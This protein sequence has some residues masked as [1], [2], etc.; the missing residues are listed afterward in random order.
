MKLGKCGSFYSGSFCSSRSSYSFCRLWSISIL[1]AW[2]VSLF[3]SLGDFSSRR[4]LWFSQQE[5][6]GT[7]STTPHPH[8]PPTMLA[9]RMVAPSVL[10]GW[11]DNSLIPNLYRLM[12][13]RTQHIV[14]SRV[15][16]LL[17]FVILKKSR[18][19][20]WAQK[21]SVPNI[22]WPEN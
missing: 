3:K 4:L 5:A 6:R 15:R 11:P 19:L 17:V 2:K 22:T 1:K 16:R 9:H 21:I 8:P 18:N 14:S 20:R 13:L 12:A 7:L 10:L